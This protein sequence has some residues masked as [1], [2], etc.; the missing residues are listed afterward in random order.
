MIMK[1][2]KR[3]SLQEIFAKKMDSE[4][5]TLYKVLKSISL[6]GDTEYHMSSQCY[7]IL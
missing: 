6:T 1:K 2:C 7:H 5:N 3:K 4:T